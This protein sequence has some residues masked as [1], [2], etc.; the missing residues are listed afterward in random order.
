MTAFL[1]T[2][3]ESVIST[4]K[5]VYEGCDSKIISH[6]KM[7]QQ[8]ETEYLMKK[9]EEEKKGIFSIIFGSSQKMSQEKKEQLEKL[10]KD[11]DF[12]SS[13]IE[14]AK[15]ELEGS[16]QELLEEMDSFLQENYS[17][18][19][20]TLNTFLHIKEL[21]DTFGSYRKRI[22]DAESVQK[23][24]K[25]KRAIKNIN[26][27]N[28]VLQD[29]LFEY[30]GLVTTYNHHRFTAE[31]EIGSSMKVELEVFP[32]RKIY[33]LMQEGISQESLSE[34]KKQVS[35]L[36]DKADKNYELLGRNLYSY[37]VSV[38]KEHDVM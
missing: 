20:L 19:R 16:R 5:V 17:D 24:R 32:S 3:L 15:H 21:K 12:H 29:T 4:Y 25:K 30:E 36:M 18:Y 10:E 7:K 34:M 23:N 11:V 27:V 8:A 37:V 22:E 35:G 1:K 33:D 9:P 2:N 28:D 38:L 31:P 14:E 6:Q 26:K 13:K